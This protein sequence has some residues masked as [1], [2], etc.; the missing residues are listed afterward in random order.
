MARTH[1]RRLIR[2]VALPGLF[3]GLAAGCYQYQPVEA[4]A[5]SIGDEVRVELTGAGQDRLQTTRAIPFSDLTGSV[6]SS[7]TQELLLQ[8]ELDSRRLGYGSGTV[9]DTVRV[10]RAD[11]REV[12][13]R[14]LSKNRSLVAAGVGLVAA[15]GIYALFTAELFSDGGGEGGGPIEFLKIPVSSILNVVGGGR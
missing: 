9:T 5:P 2:G 8:V 11:V 6:L 4:P 15:A 10:P 7:S 13:V 12:G 3:I 1:V 14:T